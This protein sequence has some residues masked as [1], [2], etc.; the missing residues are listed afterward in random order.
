[1]T[2]ENQAVAV[3]QQAKEPQAPKRQFVAVVHDPKYTR[4]SRSL[5]ISGEDAEALAALRQSLE[6]DLKPKGMLEN[7][8]VDEVTA[9]LWRLRRMRVIEAGLLT[10]A[11]SRDPK[12]N[13]SGSSTIKDDSKAL[14]IL[15][16]VPDEDGIDLP[17]RGGLEPKLGSKNFHEKSHKTE[18]I[19]CESSPRTSEEES[20]ILGR[21]FG[22]THEAL[23]KLTSHE[24]NVERSL[25]RALRILEQLQEAR[26][27][28]TV[29]TLAKVN[30]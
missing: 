11:I 1:M 4:L 19:Q 8:C 12:A 21:A 15:D 3:R 13:A 23:V 18:A 7:E 30:L 16:E 2:T 14:Q 5:V 9:C 6:E 27:A 29:L 17:R 20:C 25:N 10:Q 28:N 24:A 26:G 22:C